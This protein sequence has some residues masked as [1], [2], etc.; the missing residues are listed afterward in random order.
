MIIWPHIAEYCVDA[1][2]YVTT[3]FVAVRATYGIKAG[4]ENFVKI[5]K[6]ITGESQIENNIDSNQEETLG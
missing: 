1:M 2:S 6:Q 4:L 3:A 5:K